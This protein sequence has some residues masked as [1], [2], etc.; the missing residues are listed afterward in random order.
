MYFNTFFYSLTVSIF[1][2]VVFTSVEALVSG[3]PWGAKKVSIIQ[4]LTAYGNV[5]IQ[6]LY[7]LRWLQ[8]ELSA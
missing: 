8:V 4:E 6:S 7:L 1:F 2:A 3:H 5:K